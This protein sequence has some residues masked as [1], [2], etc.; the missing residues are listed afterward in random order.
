ML[1]PMDG[2]KTAGRFDGDAGRSSGRLFEPV[3]LVFLFLFLA[4]LLFLFRGFFFQGGVFFER[5]G[6]VLEIP[7]RRLA[8]QLLRE[9]GFA[10]WTDVHGNGQ[11]FLANPKN[12]VCYPGTWLYLILPFFTAFRFHYLIH[13]LIGWTGM[14]G[15]Q[16]FFRLRRPSAFLGASLF[17]FSGLFL[18]SFEFYNHV[19]AFAWMP[20]ILILAF[21]DSL[22]RFKK[23]AFLGILWALQLLAGTPEAVVI[24]LILALGQ[25][26]FLPGKAG[27]RAAAVLASLVLGALLSAVQ[28]LPSLEILGRT[29]RTAAE[30]SLWPLELI[31]LLNIPFPGILGSDRGPG[32]SDFWAAH[33]FDK[34]APLY[35]SF[36]LGSAGLLLAVFGLAVKTSRAGRGWRWLFLIFLLLASGRYFPLN[37]LLVRV[38]FLS[39]IRYPVKYMAGA[40]FVAAFAAGMFFD[41]YF[42][43]RRVEARRLRGGWIAALGMTAALTALV[44]VMSRGL[45]RLFVLRDERL[46]ASVRGSFY[47]GLAVL[48]AALVLMGAFGL[49]KKKAG[50][51][52]A[53]FFLLAVADP[54]VRNSS[55]N[56]VV[57]ESFYDPAAIL[58]ETGRPVT[59]YRQ[60]VLPD[61]MRIKLGGRRAQ[62]FIRQSLYP[63]SGMSDGVRY[64]FNRDFFGLHPKEQGE[65]RTAAAGWPE[66]RLLKHLRSIGCAYLI[67]PRPLRGLPAEERIF[68]GIPLA[69]QKLGPAA[70]F[71][72]FVG[73]AVVAKTPAEKREAFA[74]EDFDPAGAAVVDLPVPGLAGP[75]AAQAA[76]ARAVLET[77]GRSIY[78]MKAPAPVIAVFRGNWD[79][80]WK[81]RLDGESVPVFRVNLGLKGIVIPPGDHEV[82]IRYLPASVPAGAAVSGLTIL[83]LAAAGAVFRRRSARPGRPGRTAA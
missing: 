59:V 65:L 62:S 79:P 66:D 81:G 44:P 17:F 10:L 11:P 35:Y 7:A 73:K 4:A 47:A 60:E 53:L 63:F 16:R 30:T 26:F 48:S 45:G 13:A 37:E 24:T 74:A 80:G 33:L 67:G 29:E 82:E 3:D 25:S 40:M 69:V 72:Y 70:S 49:G 78:R 12:A 56:P 54:L 77:Q 8:V 71:P 21:S 41:D 2:G 52:A 34:G 39:S 31:Q 42:V 64:V 23:T 1:R 76:E 18:S 14:Y 43:R 15:L 5:D 50:I 55:V 38:P 58:A 36:Y 6:T 22:P 51:F 20:W 19:A 27:K 46:L 57:P 75:A 32:P 9:G 61:D 28:Y 68:E 83:A